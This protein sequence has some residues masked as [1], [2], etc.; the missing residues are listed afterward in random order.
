MFSLIRRL[1]ERV[2]PVP[3]KE[4]LGQTMF[5]LSAQRD[6]LS[7]M[8]SKLQER[9]KEMFQRCVAAQLG[10]D[11]AHSKMYA[12]EC[13]EIRKMAQIAL[14]SQL[15]LERVILRLETI[16]EFGDI[17]VQIAPVMGIVEE[18]KKRIQGLVPEVASE[19]EAV[20]SLLGDLSTE[21]GQATSHEFDI[22]TSDEEAKQVLRESSAIAEQKMR[23]QF[24]SIP[25]TVEQENK[26]EEIAMGGGGMG[27]DDGMVERLVQYLRQ[28]DG[29][30]SIPRCA[31]EL[32]ARPEEVRRAI[33]RLQDERRII[34]E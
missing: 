17:M 24:P 26:L 8:V 14:G 29:E 21:A 30:L 4:R 13:A 3:L 33:R 19:L 23:E 34:M 31:M 1:E 27:V 12:N 6:K 22:E 32:G 15:A 20:N 10:K 16:E 18:T 7:Q 5:R 25:Q 28:H 11:F 9:D 2:H